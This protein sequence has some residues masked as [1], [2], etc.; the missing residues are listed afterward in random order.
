MG[1]GSTT[2]QRTVGYNSAYGHY[3][4]GERGAGNY[5]PVG[6]IKW[7]VEV[8]LDRAGVLRLVIDEDE[9]HYVGAIRFGAAG[10]KTSLRVSGHGV[11][12]SSRRSR[13]SSSR[14]RASRIG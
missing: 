12:K 1:A 5:Y 13:A 14:S 9:L 7:D 10:A 11:P 2:F 6:E 4:D 3:P 8:T